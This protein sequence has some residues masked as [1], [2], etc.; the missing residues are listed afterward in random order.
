LLNRSA[1]G[2]STLVF[3]VEA[4]EDDESVL[5]PVTEF[6]IRSCIVCRAFDIFSRTSGS[7]A[8]V[9]WDSLATGLTTFDFSSS[10]V[11]FI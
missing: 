1:F 2:P 7:W 10:A 11:S 4:W 8:N 5:P 9:V 3:E 6:L